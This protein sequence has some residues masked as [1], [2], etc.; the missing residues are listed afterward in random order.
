M[1]KVTIRDGFPDCV[2]W[3]DASYPGELNI[4]SEQV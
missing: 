2:R 1:G 3:F 4:S